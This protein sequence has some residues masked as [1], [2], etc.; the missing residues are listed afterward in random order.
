MPRRRLKW[1]AQLRLIEEAPPLAGKVSCTGG[2]RRNRCKLDP[3]VA[4]QLL[5]KTQADVENRLIEVEKQAPDNRKSQSTVRFEQPT[6][7]DQDNITESKAVEP[8]W[9]LDLGGKKHRR[10]G[11]LVIHQHPEPLPMAPR[12][13]L[14]YNRIRREV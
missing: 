6:T 5:D 11:T 4:I 8:I 3:R 9:Q 14:D 10:P 13:R 1:D 12:K 2:R 7:L